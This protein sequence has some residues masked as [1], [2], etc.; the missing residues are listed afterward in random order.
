MFKIQIP[1][2]LGPDHANSGTIKHVEELRFGQ[3]NAFVVNILA[4]AASEQNFEREENYLNSMSSA[5]EYTI[6]LRKRWRTRDFLTISDIKFAAAANLEQHNSGKQS[7]GSTSSS[8]HQDDPGRKRSTSHEDDESAETSNGH[9][10]DG[11]DDSRDDRRDGHHAGG[12]AKKQ[13]TIR[14]ERKMAC[15]YFKRDPV[16]YNRSICCGPGFRGV[17]RVK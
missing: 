12:R 16:K 17:H 3:R 8:N 15:P 6:H 7:A 5:P 9:G 13:K 2:A 14:E 4:R 10:G 11:G 1:R